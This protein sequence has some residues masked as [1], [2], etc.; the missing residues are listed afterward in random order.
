[1]P[2]ARDTT[3]SD[4]GASGT[5][6]CVYQPKRQTRLTK[7]HLR[8]FMVVGSSL[9]LTFNFSEILKSTSKAFF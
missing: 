3:E 4:Y 1:M 9:A 2:E 8:R 5:N 6:S 7:S